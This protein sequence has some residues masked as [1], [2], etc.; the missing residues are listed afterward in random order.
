MKIET[1]KEHLL[2]LKYHQYCNNILFGGYGEQGN[3]TDR[4]NYSKIKKALF[5]FHKDGLTAID[6][7]SRVV[8]NFPHRYDKYVLWRKRP[9]IV[10][11]KWYEGREHVI[12]S[13][14]NYL[15]VYSSMKISL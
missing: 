4:G 12:K 8:M 7:A 13:D 2:R 14:V 11:F 10:N 9:I 1:K 15:W 3:G 5:Y 6:E